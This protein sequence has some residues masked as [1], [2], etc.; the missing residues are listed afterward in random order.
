MLVLKSEAAKRRVRNGKWVWC[1]VLMGEPAEKGSYPSLGLCFETDSKLSTLGS[2]RGALVIGGVLYS[3]LVP[4][5]SKE[6][7]PADHQ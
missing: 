3:F 2:S 5:R 4:S 6:N 7:L 1:L